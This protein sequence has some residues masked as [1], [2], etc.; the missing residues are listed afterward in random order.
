MAAKKKGGRYTAP[1]QFALCGM[2]SGH[3]RKPL[4]HKF[5]SRKRINKEP[6]VQHC[7]WCDTT[8]R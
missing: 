2:R 6:W 5:S 8:K 4:P 1:K 3:Y 7:S